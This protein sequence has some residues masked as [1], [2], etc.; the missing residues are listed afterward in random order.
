M[1]MRHTVLWV[2]CA[3]T[4]QALFLCVE[5]KRKGHGVCGL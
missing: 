2:Q 1:D 4:W 5:D 3:D